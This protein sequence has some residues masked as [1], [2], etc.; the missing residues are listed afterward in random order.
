MHVTSTNVTLR[1]RYFPVYSGEGM[2]RKLSCVIDTVKESSLSLEGPYL[3]TGISAAL[4]H[5][6]EL[7]IFYFTSEKSNSRVRDELKTSFTD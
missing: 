7:E 6:D 4:F 2:F 1:T 5:R 3:L